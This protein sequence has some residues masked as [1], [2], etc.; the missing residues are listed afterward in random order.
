LI[1]VSFSFLLRLKRKGVKLLC[2]DIRLRC[3]SGSKF[4]VE[5][6]LERAL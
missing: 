1:L 4:L 3:V 2:D 5:G 6:D